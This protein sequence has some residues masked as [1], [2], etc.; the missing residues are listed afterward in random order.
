MMKT[1]VFKKGRERLFET[2]VKRL[3]SRSHSF[4][5]HSVQNGKAVTENEREDRRTE[6]R[7]GQRTHKH[8]DPIIRFLLAYIQYAKRHFKKTKFSL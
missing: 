3:G 6:E 1:A 4:S 5:P 2:K 7:T 8:D